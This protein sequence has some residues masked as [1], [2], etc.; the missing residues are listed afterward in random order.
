MKSRVREAMAKHILTSCMRK[1][2]Q[3]DGTTLLEFSGIVND[4]IQDRAIKLGATLKHWKLLSDGGF[5]VDYVKGTKCGTVNGLDIND[6][7]F[8]VAQ[9][10]D[11]AE[12]PQ[13]L[14]DIR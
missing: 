3:A 11:K 12:T 8:G 13:E 14:N 9:E 10:L 5:S 4:I 2:P 6:V 7:L 1:I